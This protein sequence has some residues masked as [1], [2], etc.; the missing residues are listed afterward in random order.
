MNI[1]LDVRSLGQTGVLNYATGLLRSMFRIGREH[2]FLLVTDGNGCPW[3]NEGLTR[4]VVPSS[5]PLHWLAWSNMVLPSLLAR[6]E[7]DVYHTLKHVTAYRLPAKKVVT[8]HG[9]HIHY[10]LPNIFPWH[11]NIYWKLSYR[12]TIRRYDRIITVAEGEKKHYVDRL[13]APQQKFCVT[14]LAADERYRII[15]D[16]SQL[17]QVRARLGLPPLFILY[18]GMIHPRKNLER[19]L[20]AYKRA[21]DYAHTA[22]KLVIVGHK[23]SAYF[24]RVNTLRKQLDLVDDVMFLGRVPWDILP[25]VYNLADLFILPSLYE[26]FGIVILEAMACGVPV[27]TSDIPDIR[28]VVGRAALLINPWDVVDMAQTMASVLVNP[29]LK[30]ELKQSGLSRSAHFSWDRCARETLSV[31]QEL[32]LQ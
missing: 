8:F 14:Y 4:I 3:E 19:L 21:C 10:I 18:V 24:S 6:R 23:D 5:N 31:Y 9:G 7:I 32:M 20:R 22:H 29:G 16:R 2:T 12:A 13:G 30:R 15:E 17:E 25:A 28:E 11:D 26:G 1:C 27:I